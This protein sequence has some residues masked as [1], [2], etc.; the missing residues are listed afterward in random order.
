LFVLSEEIQLVDIGDAVR[1]KLLGEIK[2][3]PPDDILV[4]IL[5]DFL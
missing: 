1:K 5:P 3:P 4:D 2:L